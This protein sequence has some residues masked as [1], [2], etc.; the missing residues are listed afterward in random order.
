MLSLGKYHY[1]FPDVQQKVPIG[2]S[3]TVESLSIDSEFGFNIVWYCKAM[4]VVEWKW[5]GRRVP[6]LNDSRLLVERRVLAAR[7]VHRFLPFTRLIIGS[8]K[9]K[10]HWSKPILVC[11]FPRSYFVSLEFWLMIDDDWLVKM[12]R[13]YSEVSAVCG[14]KK[15]F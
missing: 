3:F 13:W 1:H 6:A 10:F 7:I 15:Y 12:K 4:S 5:R 2:S 8:L 11:T 14:N 9:Q